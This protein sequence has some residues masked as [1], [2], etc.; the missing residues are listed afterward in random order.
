MERVTLQA[1]ASHKSLKVLDTEIA[2][3]AETLPGYKNLI[4]IKG[5]GVL[6]AVTFLAAIGDVKDFPKPCSLAACLG[7]A[8][9]VI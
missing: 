1:M 3:L 9:C 7:T 6:S 8:P 4:S 5:I 2:A